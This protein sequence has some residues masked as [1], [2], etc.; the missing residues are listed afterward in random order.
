MLALQLTSGSEVRL[1]SSVC[2]GYCWGFLSRDAQAFERALRLQEDVNSSWFASRCGRQEARWLTPTRVTLS[3]SL[4]WV[5]AVWEKGRSLWPNVSV[6]HVKL[7]AWKERRGAP[8]VGASCWTSDESVPRSDCRRVGNNM[9]PHYGFC[10]CHWKWRKEPMSLACVCL[11]RCSLQLICLVLLMW[12]RKFVTKGPLNLKR[13]A[14][15]WA[16]LLFW[17]TFH[18]II[19]WIGFK[20]LMNVCTFVQDLML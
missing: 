2:S 19:S 16:S 11:M 7:A 8:S 6:S 5:T 17:V 10:L 9:R 3:R 18:L 14:V 20:K 15:F 1:W 13:F 12:P 4:F